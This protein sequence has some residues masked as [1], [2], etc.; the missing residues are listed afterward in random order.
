MCNFGREKLVTSFY[1]LKENVIPVFISERTPAIEFRFIYDAI[2]VKDT[3]LKLQR[4][5]LFRGKKHYVTGC[6]R[7]N[8][9]GIFM[10]Q[11]RG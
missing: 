2:R 10:P 5:V 8:V 11:L 3:F 1:G 9:R 7:M 6:L 4:S